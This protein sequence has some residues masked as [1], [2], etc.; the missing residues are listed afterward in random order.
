[1]LITGGT[2]GLGAELAR[3]LVAEHGVRHLV[4]TSR[5]GP[6]APGAAEL[7]AEL[8]AQGADVTLA[9][10]DVADRDAVA[11]LLAGLDPAR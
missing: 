11:A 9:A 4:L 6:D 2:G 5:R 1:M 3:H 7:R 8:T 10:C